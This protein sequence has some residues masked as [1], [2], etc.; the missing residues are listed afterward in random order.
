MKR[1]YQVGEPCDY[2]RTPC[3]EGQYGAYCKPCYI[4]WKNEKEA[5]QKPTSDGYHP[6]SV[7]TAPTADLSVLDAIEKLDKRLNSIEQAIERN[8]WYSDEILKKLDPKW[9][10]LSQDEISPDEIIK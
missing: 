1:I 2:C 3:I 10:A 6:N 4:R 8:R 5:M 9:E 7:K